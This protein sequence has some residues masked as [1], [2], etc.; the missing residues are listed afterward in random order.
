MRLRII[1]PTEILLDQTVRRV[2]AEAEDG[3]FCL[4]P[5]HRDFATALVPGIVAYVDES[6]TRR[7]AAVAEGILVKSEDDVRISTRSGVLGDD[8]GTLRM[9]VA[10][11]FLVLDERERTARSAMARLE[12]DF[13]R[14]FIEFGEPRS[15][16]P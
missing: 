1:L 10:E 12:S 14:R 16:R 6:G 13:V 9:H 7:Y 3:E 5:R 8:L 4:L 11:R 2:V 15:D